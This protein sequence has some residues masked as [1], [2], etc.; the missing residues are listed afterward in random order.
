MNTA[1]FNQTQLQ[2]HL[3][4]FLLSKENTLAAALRTAG[5]G[6]EMRL[7]RITA[8]GKDRRRCISVTYAIT[9]IDLESMKMWGALLPSPPISSDIVV[10]SST[11][12]R[13]KTNVGAHN[14]SAPSPPVPFARLAHLTDGGAAHQLIWRLMRRKRTSTD[15]AQAHIN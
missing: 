13:N 2:F 1:N 11:F 4:H 8:V 14:N 9:S 5:G 6:L 15:E 10:T 7:R 3:A 12:N